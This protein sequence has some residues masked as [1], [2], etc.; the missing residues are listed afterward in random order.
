VHPFSPH[1]FILF[2]FSGADEKIHV[3]E[4]QHKM[5][6]TESGGDQI[7]IRWFMGLLG[8]SVNYMGL[9]GLI[10]G[11]FTQFCCPI[12][13]CEVNGLICLVQGHW[14]AGC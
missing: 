12:M 11:L 7:E 3:D 5:H 9:T 13:S 4:L 14:L 10:Q 1:V 8:R 2:G 6:W